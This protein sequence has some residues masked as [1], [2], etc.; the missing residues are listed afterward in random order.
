[1]AWSWLH[2]FAV[3]SCFFSPNLSK[4]MSIPSSNWSQRCASSPK[5]RF[6]GPCCCSCLIWNGTCPPPKCDLWNTTYIKT[7]PEMTFNAKRCQ[8]HVL[9]PVKSHSIWEKYREL[10]WIDAEN[11]D[12][13]PEPWQCL[14]L[15]AVNQWSISCRLRKFP[16]AFGKLFSW[17]TGILPGDMGDRL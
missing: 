11:S 8:K 6:L 1:M 14:R 13:P 4:L 7:V 16:W 9:K 2:F 12:F 3:T 17:R 5:P 15:K 10:I